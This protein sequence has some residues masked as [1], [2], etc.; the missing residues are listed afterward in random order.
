M[1]YHSENRRPRRYFAPQLF[2]R[3]RSAKWNERT[4]HL[5][6]KPMAR[7][8]LDARF[9]KRFSGSASLDF[10]SKEGAVLVTEN[11]SSA[12]LA[13]PLKCPPQS[14]YRSAAFY[15]GRNSVA[16]RLSQRNLRHA[17]LQDP[18]EPPVEGCVTSPFGVKRLHNGKPTGEFH[19]GVDQRTP[20]GEA[21]RAI[22][23][24]ESLSQNSSM[25][26]ATRSASITVRGSARCTYT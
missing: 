2:R 11:L 1:L 18:F 16:H 14:R 22:A 4:I 25:S 5:S 3:S 23:D 9:R 15:A 10:L 6:L 17:L 21:I 12:R 20:A 24:A 26:S 19:G 7:F 13:F 8:W